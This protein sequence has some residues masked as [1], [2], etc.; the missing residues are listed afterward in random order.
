M[1][2]STGS[3]DMVASAYSAAELATMRIPGVP[4]SPRRI[5]ER[6]EREQWESYLRPRQGGP[7][8]RVYAVTSLP[9]CAQRALARR[10]ASERDATE[11]PPAPIPDVA[12]HV[13]EQRISLVDLARRLMAQ[14]LSASLAYEQ[15]AD[16]TEHSARTLRRWDLTV[17]GQAREQWATLLTPRTGCTPANASDVHPEAWAYIKSDYLRGSRPSWAACYERLLVVAA[18]RGW[19]PIPSKRTLRRRFEAEVAP[20]TVT[21]HREGPDALRRCYPAQERD[22]TDFYALQAVNADGHKLDVR[23]RWP[24]GTVERPILLGIQDVYSDK[25]LAWRV[26]KTESTE[27]VRNA[28]ADLCTRWGVPE[29]LY[30]DNG[31]AFA[32][33]KNTGGVRT[34]FRFKADTEEAAKGLLVQL[35]IQI[36]WT[37]PYSGQSKPIERYWRGLTEYVSRHPAF[38]RCYVGSNTTAKPHDYDDKHAIPLEQFL[39]VASAQIAAYNAQPHRRTLVCGGELS[40]DQA[41]EDSLALSAPRKLSESQRRIL[42]LDSELATASRTDGSVRLLGNRFWSEGCEQLKGQQL[43]L[44][45]DAD[46]VG[47]GVYLYTPAGQY[48]LHAELIE[49]TGFG[50]TTAAKDHA[51]KRT[52]FIKAAKKA[53]EAEA[54]FD[55]A[56]LAAM[57]LQAQGIHWTQPTPA[58]VVTLVPRAGRNPPPEPSPIEVTPTEPE[59]ARAVG[60][61]DFV[62]GIG[63]PLL[64]GLTPR[65]RLDD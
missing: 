40:Y 60:Q 19:Q 31:R 7:D 21:L 4:R 30:F 58:P 48:L 38:E 29:H 14:G 52:A 26:A 50:D 55:A 65:R 15:A 10:Q 46:D 43:V 36:H 49:R 64:A 42:F 16:G 59:L 9:A 1:G 2:N 47:K 34:R 35:G 5:R 17:R 8:E 23:V 41:F 32:S 57:H 45:F 25:L 37:L 62:L 44:R 39:A 27:L 28:F 11:A 33:K 51:R 53:A 18:H 3:L 24:D 61:E 6:A 22:R 56:T 54:E 12:H 63:R 20:T 13:V